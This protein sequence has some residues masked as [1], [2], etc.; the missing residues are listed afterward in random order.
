MFGDLHGFA[1]DKNMT[2]DDVLKAD[3]GDWLSVVKNFDPFDSEVSF[4]RIQEAF[5]K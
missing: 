1:S 5:L 4:E 3:I 2:R